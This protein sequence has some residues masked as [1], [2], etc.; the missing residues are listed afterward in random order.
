MTQNSVQY[1]IRYEYEYKLRRAAPRRHLN[2]LGLNLC[3]RN[4]CIR[5]LVALSALC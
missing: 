2:A 4:G 5:L 3:T 1:R